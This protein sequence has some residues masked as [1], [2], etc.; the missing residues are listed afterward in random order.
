[1]GV[2][3]GFTVRGIESAE[4]RGVQ[5]CTEIAGAEP[6]LGGVFLST[7]LAAVRHRAVSRGVRDAVGVVFGELIASVDV[8]SA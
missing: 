4:Q 2:P 5:A 8:A 7:E 6:E 3:G 1:M